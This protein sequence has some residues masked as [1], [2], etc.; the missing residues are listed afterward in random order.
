VSKQTI[1]IVPKSTNQSE[2]ITVS[3]P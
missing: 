3:E 1:Y 2:Q